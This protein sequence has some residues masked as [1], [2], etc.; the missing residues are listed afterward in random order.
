[1]E[2]QVEAC[3]KDLPSAEVWDL[4]A[5]G[6]DAVALCAIPSYPAPHPRVAGAADICQALVLASWKGEPVAVTVTPSKI[7]VDIHGAV[8]LQWC[9]VS[10]DEA[11]YGLCDVGS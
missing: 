3:D 7:A 10:I 5:A 6:V 2:D 9:Q 4:Y 1:M 11:L 8:R